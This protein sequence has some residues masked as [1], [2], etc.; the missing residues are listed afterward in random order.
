MIQTDG[1]IKTDITFFNTA[2]IVFLGAGI[3]FSYDNL[4]NRITYLESQ[5][6]IGKEV[7]HDGKTDIHDNISAELSLLQQRLIELEDYKERT[8]RCISE[9]ILL[10]ILEIR[11]KL[12]RVPHDEEEFKDIEEGVQRVKKTQIEFNN[13]LIEERK[14]KSTS[15]IANTKG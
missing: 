8:M 14:I 12:D 6:K 5:L 4:K 7:T 13:K 2:A 10:T 3:F 15:T 9:E 11:I 1:P